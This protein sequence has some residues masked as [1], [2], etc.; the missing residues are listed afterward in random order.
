MSFSESTKKH[1]NELCNRF[2]KSLTQGEVASL[3]LEGESSDYIRLNQS[4][5]RQITQVD[6]LSLQLEFHKSQRRCTLGCFLSGDLKTDEDRLQTLLQ[7]ARSECES[8]PEDPYIV[9][10]K[11]NGS[12]EKD[13]LGEHPDIPNLLKELIPT[14]EGTD[15]AG[16]YGAGPVIRANQNS[17]GQKHWFSTH[18]F[19]MDYSL[20]TVGPLGENKAAKGLYAGSHWNLDEWSIDLQ[21]QKNKLALLKR[22]SQKLSPGSYRAYLAPAALAEVASMLSWN[23]LSL[24][25][26]KKGNCAFKD[27]YE[28]RVALSPIFNLKENF[29]RGTTPQFNSLGEVSAEELILIENGKIK[30]MLVSSRAEK[31]YGVPS[32]GADFGGW[33]HEYLRAAEIGAGTLQKEEILKKLDTGIYIGNLHYLNWSD[34][35]K[36]RVTGMT[37]YACFWVENGEIQ[38][39]IQDMRFDDSLY[40]IFGSELEDL[41]ADLHFESVVDTYNQR[42]IGGSMLPGLLTSSL[43]FTL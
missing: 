35:S 21:E 6:Q 15:L 8:L 23:A 28:G 18:S 10:I 22:P 38:G 33:G 37:R 42:S 14:L 43:V 5:V 40:R 31:E 25:S 13:H 32:N 34:I 12:S 17:L 36:A 24:S 20:Y 11:N 26:L 7:R 27:L 16:F 3:N 4:K 9:S 2:F 30:N 41:T 19:F 29:K 1:F 39:P